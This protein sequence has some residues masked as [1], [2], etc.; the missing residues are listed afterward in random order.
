MRTPTLL[1][2]ADNADL[3]ARALALCARPPQAWV[4]EDAPHDTPSGNMPPWET[5]S[6]S[7]QVLRPVRIVARQGLHFG[8]EVNAF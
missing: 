3:A 8:F 7:C 4:L 1:Y 6:F 5:A 2:D